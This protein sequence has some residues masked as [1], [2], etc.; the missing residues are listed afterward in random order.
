M[1]GRFISG[2]A[3]LLVLFLFFLPWVSVSCNGLP[4]GEFSGFD[5]A[6]GSKLVDLAGQTGLI[7]PGTL[8]GD[9][10]LF[11]M[12]LIALIVLGFFILAVANQKTAKVAAWGS[13]IAGLSGI[14]VFLLRWLQLSD[15]DTM[16]FEITIQP[17]LWGTVLG[18]LLI[19]IGSIVELLLPGKT[20]VATT[21]NTSVA[22]QIHAPPPQPYSSPSPPQPNKRLDE[23]ATFKDTPPEAYKPVQAQPIPPTIM[24]SEVHPTLLEGEPVDSAAKTVVEMPPVPPHQAA[25]TEVLAAKPLPIAWLVVR[26]GQLDGQRFSLQDGLSIGRDTACDIMLPDTAVS[27]QHASV[28]FRNDQY[29]LHDHN[30]TNGCLCLQPKTTEWVKMEQIQLQDNT[31]I[32]LGRTILEVIIVPG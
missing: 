14:L 12:P 15:S 18:L 32:K 10:L 1:K 31:K 23:R 9:Q 28:S 22:P 11:I 16:F 17:G 30:S 3:A 6:L 29:T 4:I 19:V 20:A 25:K 27:N 26:S 8:S 13:M 2:P 7:A 21:L 5:L 24:E